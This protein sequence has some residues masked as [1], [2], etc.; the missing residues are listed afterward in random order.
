MVSLS[1]APPGK[2]IRSITDENYSHCLKELTF[3]LKNLSLEAV[4]FIF[5]SFSKG[6]KK[7][8]IKEVAIFLEKI[9]T[10]FKLLE[11]FALV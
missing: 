2:H 1:V 3:F 11:K 4:F 8:K 6:L 7:R 10:V 9:H 5:K